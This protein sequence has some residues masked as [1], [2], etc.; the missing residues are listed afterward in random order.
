MPELLAKR[1][2]Q[3]AGR[4]IASG[5]RNAPAGAD[6]SS[7]AWGVSSR[8]FIPAD[9][10]VRSKGE[11][12]RVEVGGP[13]LG[14]RAPLTPQHSTPSSRDQGELRDALGRPLRD[15]RLSVTDRCNLRCPYC[16]PQEV[17]GPGYRFLPKQELL[18]FEELTLVART[19][20]ELGVRK[21]RLT[22]GEPL[23]RTGLPTLV[24]MLAELGVELA[25]TTNGVLLSKHA[26]A[27]AAAGLNRVTI[28]LDG[29]SDENLR[30]MS[31]KAD[32]SAAP[33]LQGIEVAQELGLGVKVNTV[34]RKGVNEGEVLPLV[35][36][37]RHTGIAV[38]FIEYMDVGHTNRWQLDEVVPTDLLLHELGERY[39]LTPIPAAHS[40]EVAKRFQHIDGG[41]EVGF[42]SSVTQPF[43]S[44][45]SRARV[46]AK[47]E[48]FTCL[49]AAS[50]VDLRQAL[51]SAGPSAVKELV[52]S[53]WRQRQ[54]R[55]SEVRGS[56]TPE[57]QAGQHTAARRME[58]SYIGG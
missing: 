51:R 8:S 35:A 32:A 42:I 28:S 3:K 43:C 18:T 22:G 44:D 52:V 38:R 7:N 12:P 24:A 5:C 13:P 21:I 2:T 11:T 48:L 31:G 15:L 33:I 4:N 49:F 9:A 46:S 17:F 6:A 36:R 56:L 1:K 23:L 26:R 50:G 40:S 45:C 37:F 25:L 55:Y 34:V 57:L 30:R 19:F 10:L 14:I 41:G 16:M 58:M 29:L 53:S 27:L 39:P 54:D 47:G 20:I